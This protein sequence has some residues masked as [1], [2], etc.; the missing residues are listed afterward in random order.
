MLRSNHWKNITKESWKG[1][2]IARGY[3]IT[4]TLKFVNGR[5][6]NRSLAE[7]IVRHFFHK[8]DRI[9]FGRAADKKIGID[10][11]CFVEYGE[12]GQNLHIQFSAKSVIDQEFCCCFL[13]ALWTQMHTETAP[14]MKNW[15]TPIQDIERSASYNTKEVRNFRESDLG[16]LVSHVNDADINLASFDTMAQIRRTLA[17]I[18]YNDY[19]SAT[20]AYS[21]QLAKIKAKLAQ[22]GK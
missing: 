7:K 20:K 10:R 5:T 19:I 3:D 13:N 11:L 9:L 15:I 1:E 14:L 8:A 12:D 18:S 21:Y 22:S 6:I 2:I 17:H 4:G 16:L